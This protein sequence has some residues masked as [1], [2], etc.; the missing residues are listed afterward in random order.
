[1]LSITASGML[2]KAVD[3]CSLNSL[4]DPFVIF[5]AV[6]SFPT[7]H[8]TKLIHSLCSLN[9]VSLEVSL[10]VQLLYPQ[11][12]SLQPRCFVA[13]QII[14]SHSF[15]DQMLS[16]NACT[17]TRQRNPHSFSHMAMGTRT[18]NTYHM[19]SSWR[20]LRWTFESFSLSSPYT[21][22]IYYGKHEYY[23]VRNPGFCLILH[24]TT[25]VKPSLF[26]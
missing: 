15:L 26:R 21:R 20:P 23:R 17:W 24:L 4:K 8:F 12:L 22:F 10:I 7:Y 16:W 5:R 3:T 6:A 9:Q 13:D 14:F 1:M 18:W 25:L 11:D 2:S 19:L